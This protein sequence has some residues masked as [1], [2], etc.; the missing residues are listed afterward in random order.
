VIDNKFR[1]PI[2]QMNEYISCN[3]EELASLEKNM[4]FLQ[5]DIFRVEGMMAELAKKRKHADPFTRSRAKHLVCS[6]LESLHQ[7]ELEVANELQSKIDIENEKINAI[8]RQHDDMVRYKES[9][10][11]SIVECKEMV[12]NKKDF[13]QRERGELREKIYELKSKAEGIDVT[14]KKLED[15]LEEG[16]RIVRRKEYL[17]KKKEMLKSSFSRSFKAQLQ[18]EVTAPP[19]ITTKVECDVIT[20]LPNSD[21]HDEGDDL[22]SIRRAMLSSF[23]VSIAHPVKEELL[24]PNPAAP[25]SVVSADTQPPPSITVTKAVSHEVEHGPPIAVFRSVRSAV[26]AAIFGY[27]EAP[28]HTQNKPAG[29]SKNERRKNIMNKKGYHTL[30]KAS[31]EYFRHMNFHI[32]PVLKVIENSLQELASLQC[33]NSKQLV[34]YMKAVRQLHRECSML[35]IGGHSVLDI[36]VSTRALCVAVIHKIYEEAPLVLL[37]QNKSNLMARLLVVILSLLGIIQNSTNTAW[38]HGLHGTLTDVQEDAMENLCLE[39]IALVLGNHRKGLLIASDFMATVRTM[40]LQFISQNNQNYQ[41]DAKS[42]N[43]VETILNR[44]M[45]VDID[46]DLF[47]SVSDIRTAVVSELRQAAEITDDVDTR[48][49]HLSFDYSMEFTEAHYRALEAYEILLMQATCVQGLSS[50]D[51]QEERDIGKILAKFQVMESKFSQNLTVNNPANLVKSEEKLLDCMCRGLYLNGKRVKSSFAIVEDPIATSTNLESLLQVVHPK[52]IGAILALDLFKRVMSVELSRVKFLGE[53]AS[54]KEEF[55]DLQYL[56]VQLPDAMIQ[57]G[58]SYKDDAV[59]TR[60]KELAPLIPEAAPDDE[61]N[62]SAIKGFHKMFIDDLGRLFNKQVNDLYALITGSSSQDNT[63]S[64]GSGRGVLTRNLTSEMKDRLMLHIEKLYAATSS[65][66]HTSKIEVYATTRDYEGLLTSLR[67]GQVA[68]N[69]VLSALLKPFK[70]KY[71]LMQKQIQYLKQ[72]RLVRREE[73]LSLRNQASQVQ[74]QADFLKKEYKTFRKT[75][76]ASD[77]VV[78]MFNLERSDGVFEGLER[79]LTQLEERVRD[80]QAQIKSKHSDYNHLQSQEQLFRAMAILTK[81]GD[82]GGGGGSG[83]AEVAVL[84]AQTFA[85]DEADKNATVDKKTS[86]KQELKNV[87]RAVG[88]INAFKSNAAKPE[89][90]SAEKEHEKS[91]LVAGFVGKWKAKLSVLGPQY[92]TNFLTDTIRGGPVENTN[93]A[94]RRKSRSGTLPTSEDPGDFL[95]TVG[96]TDYIQLEGVASNRVQGS[97]SSAINIATP[98]FIPQSNAPNSSVSD[99]IVSIITGLS[100]AVI[101]SSMLDEPALDVADT[102]VA[103][104]PPDTEG[105]AAPD[106][107]SSPPDTALA[108]DDSMPPSTAQS[109]ATNAFLADLPVGIIPMQIHISIPKRNIYK[110]EDDLDRTSIDFDEYNKELFN[111]DSG[112]TSDSRT[113]EHVLSTNTGIQGDGAS[114]PIDSIGTGTIAGVLQQYQAK[115]FGIVSTY[116]PRKSQYMSHP[117]RPY[118]VNGQSRV[119]V[120]DFMQRESEAQMNFLLQD[121]N[122][123]T[124][125]ENEIITAFARLNSDIDST[126]SVVETQMKTILDSVTDDSKVQPPRDP[127]PSKGSVRRQ[128]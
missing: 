123:K 23:L 19:A 4:I 122:E 47:S 81:E 106:T 43:F 44:L 34:S 125:F 57:S 80:L 127:R 16:R 86:V 95:F 51:V 49:S 27:N 78:Q 12:S 102:A 10:D 2:A 38:E 66:S 83:D 103:I 91:A 36:E 97:K 115:R 99:T 82:G 111:E 118:N 48:D 121:Q 7:K 46:Y 79:E 65:R 20:E 1:V 105:S 33:V 37:I 96:G 42:F 110:E 45:K 113:M 41:V 64:T 22:E 50:L 40:T 100:A 71:K 109:N 6:L 117:K 68:L 54:G 88:V 89:E 120:A 59:L 90:K 124:N 52:L 77:E 26:C 87:A 56:N 14:V 76:T 108:D 116:T 94:E 93:M 62:K 84:L 28:R 119:I 128:K 29:K 98:P 112:H 58:K 21:D 8:Q 75:K 107:V 67:E 126:V 114:D 69:L 53:I 73:L 72:E 92:T 15:V 17:E 30:A 35:M 31:I 11:E 18:N 3:N 101:P 24:W 61:D 85:F 63:V 9:L 60:P 74:D 104:V 13:M 55:N 25:A 32:H 70:S 5:K 39:A